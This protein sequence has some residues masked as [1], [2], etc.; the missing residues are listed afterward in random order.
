MPEDSTPSITSAIT[1]D[2]DAVGR[3][4]RDM[5]AKGAVAELVTALLSLFTRMRTVNA[6][7]MK[8]LAQKSKRLPPSETMRR[9]QLELPLMFVPPANDDGDKPAAPPPPPSRDKKKR[10]AKNPRPHGR[11]KLPPHLVRVVR[12]HLVPPE[13]RTC[14]DCNVPLVTI[15]FKSSETLGRKT[16]EY[17]AWHDKYETCACP[18]CHEHVVSAPRRD[19]VV[20]RG[21]LGED[22]LTEALVDHY[23]DA[24][25]WERMERNAREQGVPLSANTL[26]ASVGRVIDLFAPVVEHIKEACLASSFTACDATSMPVLDIALEPAI[27]TGALWL[28]EGAHKYAYFMYAPSAHAAHVEKLLEDRTLQSVMCDG[29]P[30]NNCVERAGG[31]RGGCNAHSRRKLVHALRLG[32]ARAARGIEL[33]ARLFHVDAESKRLGESTHERFARRQKESAPLVN[34]LHAWLDHMIPDVE[35]KSALGNA[36]WYMRRQWKRLMRF[37]DDPLMEMSNNE[38]EG[39]IRPWVL[40]RKTWLFVGHEASARRAA[41]ALS[42]ITT[43]RKLGVEPRR[44]FR[45]A[46]AKI[47]AGEKHLEA[48]LPEAFAPKI[49]TER[50]AA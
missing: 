30:T 3:F 26:A 22:L 50:A 43:C 23:A 2:L 48:I 13:Q 5:V 47:L 21:I 31:A 18:K 20:D 34:E 19:R 40:N 27:R 8:K 25:P 10:G 7:L 28:F 4:I 15:G 37:L 38:V 46:L 49:A 11:P 32:D 24:V 14:T 12:P 29:S 35:P 17:F 36:L 6:E 45:D 42:I 33:Y 1:P 39:D 9:L 16:L 41:D 44:Y